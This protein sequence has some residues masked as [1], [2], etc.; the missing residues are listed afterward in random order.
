MPTKRRRAT[1]VLCGATI[2]IIFLFSITRSFCI[3]DFGVYVKGSIWLHR[4]MSIRDH[5]KF[6]NKGNY[7]VE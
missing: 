4:K 2:Q 5:K 7:E 1:A 3:V 6:S